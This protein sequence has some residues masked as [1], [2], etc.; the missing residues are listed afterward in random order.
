M[1]SSVKNENCFRHSPCYI[2]RYRI[3][4]S[5][6]VPLSMLKLIALIEI[7]TF[8]SLYLLLFKHFDPDQARQNK[9]PDQDPNCL[10]L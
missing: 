6:S 9:G 5:G 8:S 2:L 10:V 3:K 7:V 4:Q 1:A